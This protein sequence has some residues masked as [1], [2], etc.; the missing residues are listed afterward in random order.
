MMV[1]AAFEFVDPGAGPI[2]SRCVSC[3]LNVSFENSVG[4]TV[5]INLTLFT[6]SA[7]AVGYCVA[8]LVC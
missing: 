8:G 6:S 4:K 1:A 5:P 7:G 2:T 3:A